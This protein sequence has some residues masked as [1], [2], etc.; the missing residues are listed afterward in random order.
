MAKEMLVS[1]IVKMIR[2]QYC[3]PSYSQ[4]AFGEKLGVS[5]SFIANIEQNAKIPNDAFLEKISMAMGSNAT[6]RS[7]FLRELRLAA[8]RESNKAQAVNVLETDIKKI[9]KQEIL[10]IPFELQTLIKDSMFNKGI[11]T[12]QIAKLL[13]VSNPETTSILT[14][15]TPIKKT[16]FV[17][18]AKKIGE[19]PDDWLLFC[20]Y[21]PGDIINSIQA[22]FRNN[23]G[24]T[25]KE[26][27]M[28]INPK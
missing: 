4:K 3:Q 1:Q 21:I 5:R 11:T 8:S 27:Q 13:S 2:T 23:P 24:A 9:Q 10:F 26:L 25:F 6:D 16:S 12:D 7:Y 22:F 28:R 17:Q 20:G 15:N 19:N 18:L 14:G